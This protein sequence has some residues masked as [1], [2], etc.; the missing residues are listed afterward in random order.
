MLQRVGR[1]VANYGEQASLIIAVERYE[2]RYQN[3]PAGQR[4]E[5]KL[6]AEFALFKTRD[7]TGWVGFR[8]VI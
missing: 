4:S 6:L 2:Q 3:A 1:Y 5:R 8:D 7:A